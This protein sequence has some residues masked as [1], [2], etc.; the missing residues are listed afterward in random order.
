[1]KFNYT[2]SNLCGTVYRGGNLVFTPDGDSIYSPVGNRVSSF[3]LVHNK[4]LTFPFENRTNVARVVVSPDG[5]TLLTIDED[6]RGLLIAVRR[7]SVLHHHSFKAKVRAAEFSPDGSLLAVAHD[8]QVHVWQTPAI[9]KEFAPFRIL[10]K[11][12]G[13]HDDVVGITWTTQGDYFVA[14]SKDR[15]ARI[16]STQP[17]EGFVPVTLTGHREALVGV[18]FAEG[19][20]DIYTVSRDGA[21]FE[22]ECVGQDPEA[23]SELSG[24]ED[25]DEAPEAPRPAMCDWELRNKH[26]FNH[27]HAKVTCATFHK[28]S[29]LVCV[30]MSSGVFALHQMPTF[31]AIQALSISQ[32][33]ITAATFNPSGEWLALGCA[34]LG[35]LLVWEWQSETYVLKQQGHFF[36][37]NCLAYS[38]DGQFIAT[39]G[40]DNKVKLWSTSSGFCFVTFEEH[41][42]PISAI[43]IVPNGKTVLSA[44]MDGTVR[45]FDLVRYR[46]FRTLSTPSP[47]QLLSLAVD[48]S[49]EVACAGALE[50]FEVYVWSVQTGKL[51]EVLTGHT[52]P[53]SGLAF[54]PA[55]ATLA[56]CS[57]DK[58]VR[59]WDVY[60]SGKSSRVAEEPLIHESDILAL[61]FRPDGREVCTTTLSGKLLFWDL[62]TGNLVQ[63]I[64]G[65]NDIAGG[66]KAKDF[67]TAKNN[68]AGKAF[69]SVTYSADGRC[70]LAGGESKFVCIYEV[71][72]AL[73]VKKFQMSE[74]R[75]LDGVLDMLNSK[76]MTDA[77]PNDLIDNSDDDSDEDTLRGEDMPGQTRDL[78][79]RSTKLAIRTKG[80]AFCP[81]GRT[82]AAATTEGLMI[83][84]LDEALVFDPTDLDVDVTPATARS[85]FRSAQF[86]RA[87]LL[88]LRL[89]EP[90][91]IQEI[92]EGIPASEIRIV[93]Q[94]VPPQYLVRVLSFLA[95]Q[96]QKRPHIEFSLNWV[97]A[98][99]NSHR[100]HLESNTGVF[101]STLKALHHNIGLHHDAIAKIC[102]RN[103]FGLKYIGF[104]SKHGPSEDREPEHATKKARVGD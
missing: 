19:D 22:W 21:L 33:P 64:E 49:G 86:T 91:L 2:F 15:T 57:W 26:F 99:M 60:A 39:G 62:N 28:A 87:L 72:H 29:G 56:S 41:S 84:A 9:A 63:T 94:S 3:D 89:N 12:T 88:A 16:F 68:P 102:D 104:L 7:R 74:N 47:V 20:R 34:A 93:A 82:W 32:H 81:T 59:M 4:S 95:E 31:E 65:R 61:A 90:P 30:G 27:N 46:N 73:L 24:Q 45:C 14:C 50:P 37:T 53:I 80:V 48:A 78:S 96:V 55:K 83:H 100:D 11:Y 42:G 44:S 77:G 6:G 97:L 40:D 38:P 13:L 103:T 17:Q 35:Q 67:M 10:R 92:L 52:G 43:T 58:E 101:V 25:D 69:T 71:R 85:A 75:S 23:D 36:D 18:Y 70:V 66:R 5:N 8:N 79:K 1:M 76:H 98:L 54:N 51:L